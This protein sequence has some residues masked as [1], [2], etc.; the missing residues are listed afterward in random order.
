V[1]ENNQEEQKQQPPRPPWNW[2]LDAAQ[3][4]FGRREPAIKVSLLDSKV[5]SGILIG[6]DPYNLFIRQPN[7]RV[8]MV[9]K[10]AVKDCQ[11][12][13]LQVKE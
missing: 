1:S 7:E 2:G 9:P 13:P 4:L 12:A 8:L 6:V 5:D 11:A 3:F 10:H